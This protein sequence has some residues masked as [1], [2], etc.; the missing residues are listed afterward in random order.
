MVEEYPSKVLVIS[1]EGFGSY[2]IA[3]NKHNEKIDDGFLT[4]NRLGKYDQ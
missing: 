2:Y 1:Q 3:I 4:Q